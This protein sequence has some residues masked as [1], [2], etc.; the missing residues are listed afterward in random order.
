MCDC[1]VFVFW[2]FKLNVGC[3]DCVGIY[4]VICL[5]LC[6]YVLVDFVGCDDVVVNCVELVWYDDVD[7]V[8]VVEFR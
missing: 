7:V 4:W 5:F 6:M 8:C 1:C 2:G 3:F